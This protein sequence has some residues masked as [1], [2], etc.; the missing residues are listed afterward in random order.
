PL[1]PPQHPVPSGDRRMARLI[2]RALAAGG[3]AVELMS[4]V[5]SYCAGPDD[6]AAAQH[7][8]EVAAQRLGRM[9]PAR[10]RA[11]V[12]E[13]WLTYHLYYKA[14]DWIGPAVATAL[15]IPYLVAEASSAAKRLASDW[16]PGE[17]AVARALGRA[18]AVL[19]LNPADDA[20]VA[21]HLDRPD[22][23][24]RLLPFLDLTAEPA[25]AM[26]RAGLAAR[27]DIPADPP[28]L[29]AV[30]MMRDGDK[31][32]SYRLLG[33][34]LGRI[35][36]LDW[37]LL[38]AGDGSARDAVAAVLGPRAR[39]LGACPPELLQAL[40]AAADLMVWPAVNEAFG[41]ALL[42]ARA[43]GL[44]V[45]AGDQGAVAT[46]VDDGRSG[47]VIAPLS[48]DSFAAAMRALIVDPAARARMADF[49]RTTTGAK[50]GLDAA[51]RTLDS[52]L[53]FA[54]AHRRRPVPSHDPEPRGDAAR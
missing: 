26:D 47:L 45:V 36:D 44:P 53:R 24:H 9:L 52:A 51:A 1:K 13:A 19:S 43:A 11:Q 38:V 29:L 40:Y 54:A 14:P 3:H 34:A 39:L 49:A 41:M 4:S 8:A 33:Q 32:A 16:A 46:I 42:E 6:L 2:M 37:Q 27:F 48:V 18:D 22:R 10:P 20:G 12:P 7:T 28:W 5:R 35:D 23:I 31:L 25:P 15:D 21:V 17:R 50:H 30:A